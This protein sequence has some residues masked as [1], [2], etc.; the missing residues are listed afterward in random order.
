MRPTQG[1]ITLS[2]REMQRVTVLAD[3]TQGRLA[4]ARAAEL[5][6]I[7]VRHLKRLKRRYRQ[8]GEAALA[9]ASR[10]RPSPR[11]LPQPVRQR[12]LRLARTTYAGFNDHHL[13]EKLR[14]VEG[15][16]LSRETLRRL[17]RA[18]GIGPPRKRRP[19]AHRQRRARRPREGEMLQVDGS[20]HDWLEGRGEPLT[21]LGFQ[22][23]ATGKVVGAEFFPTETAHGYFRVWRGVL[24]RYGVPLSL[25]GDR[26]GV[27]VRN[28]DHWTLDEQLAGRQQPTQ[29]GRALEQLGVTFI[30]ANSPQ[31]KGRIERLWGVF[32]DRL[33]SELRLAG[34][35][36]LAS[37]NRVL[38][39]FLPDYN[40]RFGRAPAH[41]EQAWR[42]APRDLDRI[43]C[44]IHERIVSN[45]NVVQWD[46]RRFQI[47]P[48]PRRFSF[49]GARVQLYQDLAGR[50]AVYHGETKLQIETL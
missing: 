48:Q 50:I 29:F 40:R 24:R 44:F 19:P 14:E 22:D 2:I 20:P 26:C 33:R 18:A 15:L 46:G 5:L 7:S 25:Y 3:C 21:L 38:R 42:P 9:H 1:T 47:P 28:D 35:N 37:A 45:D 13:T 4:C 6:G 8:G 34:A 10:G 30:P 17:L 12:I 27:F 36:D 31:A 39:R 16:E 23:D 49:A 41:A 11:G 43:C 32:Q